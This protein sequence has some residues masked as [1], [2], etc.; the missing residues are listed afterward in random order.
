[1]LGT[2][3]VFDAFSLGKT[4]KRHDLRVDFRTLLNLRRKTADKIV[5]CL[6][7]GWWLRLRA[8]PA[9]STAR[10]CEHRS[11][12]C[13]PDGSRGARRTVYFRDPVGR[14]GIAQPR[15]VGPGGIAGGRPRGRRQYRVS[16][17]IKS[18]RP[19]AEHIFPNQTRVPVRRR[20]RR[21]LVEQGRR[22]PVRGVGINPIV[23][24]RRINEQAAEDRPRFPPS[25]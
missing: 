8:S 4:G 2:P 15:V 16:V 1:M 3:T 20:C 24:G 10:R 25:E 22:H 7:R 21:I 11:R 14:H 23:G 13:N 17:F 5:G 19:Q 18:L 12:Q 9:E 6:Q